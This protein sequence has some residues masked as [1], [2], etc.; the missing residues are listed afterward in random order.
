MSLS[1]LYAWNSKSQAAPAAACGTSCGSGNKAG[2]T[3]AACGTSCGS[4]NKVVR[5]AAACGTAC[6]AKA[7][8]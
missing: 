7:G 4:G 2:R 3:A 6:G 1:N 5:P 8:K